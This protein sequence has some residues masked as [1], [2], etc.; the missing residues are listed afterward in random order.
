[1]ILI[2]VLPAGQSD[3]LLEALRRMKWPPSANE[4]REAF[5]F[6][7]PEAGGFWAPRDCPTAQRLWI[8]APYRGRPA[9]L[10]LFMNYMHHFLQMQ[11]VAVNLFTLINHLYYSYYE[12][13]ISC[14]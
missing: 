12:E 4:T 10:L 13:K 2:P 5:P 3:R 6:E 7:Q 9:S 11:R 8:V 1:M 14:S